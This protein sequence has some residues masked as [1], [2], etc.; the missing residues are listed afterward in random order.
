M[1]IVMYM[2]IFWILYGIAGLFGIQNIPSK[3][4]GY[5]WT[6]EYIRSQGISWL[7]IGVPWFIL[8]LVYTFCLIEMN[9]DRGVIVLLIILLAVPSIIYTFKWDKKYRDL[10]AK[11]TDYNDR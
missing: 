7:L 11:E 10:L 8:Y 2:S 9:I 1:Q 6:K 4:K 5:S 3:Y